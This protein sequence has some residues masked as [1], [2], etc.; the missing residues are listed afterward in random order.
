MHVRQDFELRHWQRFGPCIAFVECQS[1]QSFNEGAK[2]AE[3]G[4]RE[5]WALFVCLCVR[6]VLAHCVE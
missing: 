2:W 4:V 1:N 5:K 6:H 3:G